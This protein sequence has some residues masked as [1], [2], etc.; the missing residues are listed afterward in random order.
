MNNS[1]AHSTIITLFLALS[2]LFLLLT[3]SGLTQAALSI[4]Y[5]SNMTSSATTA[6][7]TVKFLQGK[8]YEQIKKEIGSFTTVLSNSTQ[9]NAS[10]IK[11][12]SDGRTMY[13]SWL[14]KIDTINHLFLSISSNGGLNFSE[15][16]ELSPPNT[17]N[18]SN[19]QIFADRRAVAL[20]WQATNSTTDINSI[21]FSRSYDYGANFTTIRL[22][23]DNVNAKG[24]VLLDEINVAWIETV[25]E[26]SI[27]PTDVAVRYYWRW[28]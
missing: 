12:A 17:G 26:T 11:A 10:D 16:I 24:P 7:T 8:E 25:N 1:E 9:G 27:D 4:S 22:T 3:L 15:P 19:V 20:A 14:G 18:V 5:P 13:L 6:N 21:F 2:I 23:D 28:N